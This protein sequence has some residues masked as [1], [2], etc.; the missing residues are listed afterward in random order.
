MRPDRLDRRALNRATL[1]RQLLLER[2]RISTVD[3]VEHLVG[4][5]SQ[6]PLAHYVALWSRIDAF[7]P[8]AAGAALERKELVRTH[9][10]RATVHLFSRR[11]ALQLRALTRPMLAARFASSPF[12]KLLPGVDLAAVCRAARGIT[13][14]APVGRVELGRRLSEQFPGVDDAALAYAVTYMEPMVQVPPRAVWGK[15]GPVRWQTFPGW[16]GAEADEP[17]SIDEVVMRYLGAFGPATVAD[18]R[19][20]SG[21]PALREVADRLRPQLRLFVDDRGRELLDLPDA[22]RPDPGIPAPVRF[23][24][25]YDNVL[26]S[27]DDRTR[28]IPDRRPVP[29]PPGDGARVGTVLVDGDFRATWELARRGDSAVLTARA[30]PPLT[31][32]EQG[33]VQDEAGRLLKFLAPGAVPDVVIDHEARPGGGLA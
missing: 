20:W 18:M 17:A 26:L 33:D 25:E 15:R 7:D 30:T 11:D 31:R 3:A 4:V 5:Q 13:T 19:I 6:A 32:R 23:L 24:P 21:L 1:A 8:V 2:A 27:H 14:Q 29:L 9:A 12:P 28:V 22:P 10:M 16:L